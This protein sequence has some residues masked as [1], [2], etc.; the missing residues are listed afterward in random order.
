MAKLVDRIR[1]ALT[2]QLEPGEELRSVGQVT[3]GKM[4]TAQAMV[5]T[6]GIGYLPTVKNW[7]V[8]V[9]DGETGGFRTVYRIQQAQR[10]AILRSSDK[11]QADG[12]GDGSLRCRRRRLAGLQVPLRG[13]VCDRPRRSGIHGGADTGTRARR[14]AS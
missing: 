7:W 8:G 1:E 5:L 10:R 6:G 13:Q 2:P 12:Q 14:L 3:S 11:C 4:S 9:S